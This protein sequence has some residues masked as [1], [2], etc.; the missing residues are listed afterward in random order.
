MF[1]SNFKHAFCK[2][3]VFCVREWEAYQF[4]P[5]KIISYESNY[6]DCDTLGR[7]KCSF[8]V[9]YHPKEGRKV[10]LHRSAVQRNQ[11]HF[12]RDFQ[13]LMTK[14]THCHV[15]MRY[16]GY[17]HICS[18]YTK[19]EWK[20]IIY[21][22]TELWRNVKCCLPLSFLS[23]ANYSFGQLMSNKKKKRKKLQCQQRHLWPLGAWVT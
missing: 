20:K 22:V 10:L 19:F 2:Q 7:G 23:V 17:H 18:I 6:T 14:T 21:C 11:K 15:N 9:V 8:S 1:L 13:K 16:A 5:I 3:V 4:I 12:D